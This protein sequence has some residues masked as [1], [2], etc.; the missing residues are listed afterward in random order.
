MIIATE[1]VDR[2]GQFV[3]HYENVGKALNAAQQA[4]GDGKKKLEDRGQSIVLSANKLIEL[5]AKNGKNAVPE[6]E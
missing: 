1:M 5:G 3:K 4:Y 2:V 6:V